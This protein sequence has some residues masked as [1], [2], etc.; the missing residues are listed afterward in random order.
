MVVVG[1]A[2][3]G[4]R[5]WRRSAPTRPDVVLMDIRMPGVD[6][7][8]A[9]GRIAADPVAG[10]RQGGHPDDV[11]DGRV[12]LRG[13]A[14]GAAGFLVKGIGPA[15][16]SPASGRWPRG[17]LLSPKATR[18]LIEEF[19]RLQRRAGRRRANAL[20]AL[21][22]RERE[23]MA[24]VAH[25]LTNEEI[26]GELYMSPADGEDPRQPDHDEARRPRPGPAG[27][28]RL[29]DGPGSR[30]SARTAVAVRARVCGW[31][32]TRSTPPDEPGSV[33]TSPGAAT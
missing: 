27:R 22:A 15:A 25:G 4:A 31:T 29:P 12:R 7:I 2:A 10:R 28:A 21:T 30:L 1:E 3:D 11:R 13:P 8:E 24:L 23:V 26:A 17:S 9:T 32:T 20:A 6:G 16:C 33:T 5:R 19:A 18:S 14:A